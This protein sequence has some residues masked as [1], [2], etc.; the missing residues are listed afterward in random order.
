MQ[1][2]RKRFETSPHPEE[3]PDLLLS[4]GFS[5]DLCHKSSGRTSTSPAL[6]HSGL[7]D[8]GPDGGAPSAVNGWTHC[9]LSSPCLPRWFRSIE[10]PSE[11]RA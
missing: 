1:I 3:P 10:T 11:E 4:R 8:L 5:C 6:Q 2:I 9:V 7:E